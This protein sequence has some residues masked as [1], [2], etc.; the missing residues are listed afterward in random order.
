[1]SRGKKQRIKKKLKNLG[2]NKDIPPVEIKTNNNINLKEENNKNS[3]DDYVK[4]KISNNRTE[5]NKKM[6]N[7]IKEKKY[8]KNKELISKKTRIMKKKK[9]LPN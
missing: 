2:Y 4:I 3:D 7:K 5:L 8:E 6:K 9:K 1:M